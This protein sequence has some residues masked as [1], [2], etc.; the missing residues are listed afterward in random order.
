[1][2]SSNPSRRMVSIRIAQLQFA[3]TRDL[4]GIRRPACRSDLAAPHCPRPRAIRRSRITPDFA[5]CRPR[6]PASGPSLMRNVMEMR[7]RIDRLGCRSELA[8]SAVSRCVSATVG[9]R[10]TPTIATIGRRPRRAHPLRP[11]SR[12]RKA[13]TAWKS[14]KPSSINSLPSRDSAL[15]ASH[16][17]AG[18]QPEVDAAGQTGGRGYGI[19]LE[20]RRQHA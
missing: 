19:G 12:P 4:E 3:A 1:M 2:V 15:I 9:F 17:A 7:R 18:R 8:T 5:P 6:L 13:I 14:R 16:I 11:V 10:H 20:R